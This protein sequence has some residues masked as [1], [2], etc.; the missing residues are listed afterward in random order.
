[1]IFLYVL[2]E[3]IWAEQSEGAAA[4]EFQ[5][6]EMIG[7]GPFRVVEY[8]QNEFIRLAAVEDHFLNPPKIDEVIFHFLPMT[9]RWCKPSRRGKWTW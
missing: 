7:T 1:M 5:N 4:T 9:M 3:H 8:Q 6:L 2:P